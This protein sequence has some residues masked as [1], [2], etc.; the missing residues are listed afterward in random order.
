MTLQ[1]LLSVVLGVVFGYIAAPEVIIQNIDIIIDF[2]LCLLLFFVGIDIGTNKEI[3]SDIKGYGHKIIL[4]PFM[5]VIGT[6]FGSGLA[7]FLLK[8]SIF[9]TAAVGAGFG[10]Y[11]LSAIELSKYSAELG[12]IAFLTNVLREVLAIILMPAIA[13]HIGYIET[14]AAAG[15][16]A[17][18]TAL[19]VITRATNSSI[20]IISFF[21]GLVLS[22][23]VP[24]LVPLIISLN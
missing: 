16:T 9:E 23:L 11:S 3:L 12:T 2:G 8:L 22:T 14:I 24:I 20:S 13:K 17:M 4:V 5:I 18:D 1:I 19:P 6:L 21:S 15:A 10:W 7:S